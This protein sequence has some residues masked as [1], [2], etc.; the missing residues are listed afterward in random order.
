[1]AAARK[2]FEATIGVEITGKDV[3]NRVTVTVTKR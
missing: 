1:M 3:G 2:S